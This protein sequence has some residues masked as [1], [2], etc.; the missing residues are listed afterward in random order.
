[1]KKEHEKEIKKL[2]DKINDLLFYEEKY[3][4]L[5]VKFIFKGFIDY[6]FLIFD[7]YIEIKNDDKKCIR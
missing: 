1:M 6:L 3:L 4:C 2:N 7:I 5:K